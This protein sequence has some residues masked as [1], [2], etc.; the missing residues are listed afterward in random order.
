MKYL[1]VA[2]CLILII[3]AVI[4]LIRFLRDSFKGKCCENCKN[5]NIENC[6]NRTD[7]NT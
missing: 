3:A 2:F 4:I 5:C 7:R 1:I 6:P